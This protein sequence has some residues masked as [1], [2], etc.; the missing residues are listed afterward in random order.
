M[1]GCSPILA[2]A[3]PD[4]EAALV[5]SGRPGARGTVAEAGRGAAGG[6]GEAVPEARRR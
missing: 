2:V 6:A 4:F 1:R 5:V 3:G